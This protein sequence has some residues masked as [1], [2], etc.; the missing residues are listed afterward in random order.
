M[1][2]MRARREGYSGRSR[3]CAVPRR[4]VRSILLSSAGQG[5]MGGILG[6]QSGT[7]ARN[8]EIQRAQQEQAELARQKELAETQ[9]VNSLQDTLSSQTNQI[10]RIFGTR[11]LM[12][13]TSL[14]AGS[15]RS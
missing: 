6:G 12:A 10:A 1:R 4:P 3:A 8:A 11:A 14:A 5:R 7:A 9:Q 15:A 2:L 13:G